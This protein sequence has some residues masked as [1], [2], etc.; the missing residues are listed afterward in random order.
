[1]LELSVKPVLT[2]L[3]GTIV[4]LFSQDE[5]LK[6][7]ICLQKVGCRIQDTRDQFGKERFM[8]NGHQEMDTNKAL[9]VCMSRSA[10]PD[11]PTGGC[12][13]SLRLNLG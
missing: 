4:Y 9:Q 11:A 12:Q 2:R 3:P 13:A 8:G 10:V 7:S 5:D 6:T 1:M